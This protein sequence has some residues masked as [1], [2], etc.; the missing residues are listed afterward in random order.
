[1]LVVL[2]H[3]FSMRDVILKLAHIVMR[4]RLACFDIAVIDGIVGKCLHFAI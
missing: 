3:R 4:E 1:M 2:L